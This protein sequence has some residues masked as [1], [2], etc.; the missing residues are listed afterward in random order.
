MRLFELTGSDEELSFSPYV[1]RIRMAL[2]HKGIEPER[3][4]T[5]FGDKSAF[6]PSAHP[7]CR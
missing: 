2:A 1:W 7:L 5:R 6:A 4:F 3:V